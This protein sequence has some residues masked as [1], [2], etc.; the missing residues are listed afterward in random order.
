[1]EMQVRT[2]FCRSWMQPQHLRSKF[3]R[4]PGGKGEPQKV[5]GKE[6]RLKPQVSPGGV[7]IRRTNSRG[8]EHPGKLEKGKNSRRKKK[9]LPVH[10]MA[11]ATGLLCW[12]EA[13]RRTGALGSPHC[14]LPLLRLFP[15][16][17]TSSR[18]GQVVAKHSEEWVEKRVHSLCTLEFSVAKGQIC[19]H[20]FWKVS[21]RSEVQTPEA[22]IFFRPRGEVG[23]TLTGRLLMGSFN[24]K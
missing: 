20:T 10:T 16:L 8:S 3:L 14:S 22:V 2:G 19:S 11:G 1:M 23:L 7:P 18:E 6:G 21:G 4:V 12:P 17:H 24:S 13:A 15:W 9:N 5:L